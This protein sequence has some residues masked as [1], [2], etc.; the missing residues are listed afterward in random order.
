MDYQKLL[1]SVKPSGTKKWSKSIFDYMKPFLVKEI[2]RVVLSNKKGNKGPRPKIRNIDH[3]LDAIFEALDTGTKLDYLERTHNI[4]RA[5]Y[6]R[7]LK[8]IIDHRLFVKLHQK[9]LEDHSSP[10]L[11]L[12]DGSHIRSVN[13]SEG[14]NYGYKEKSKS[15]LKLTILT[16]TNKVIYLSGLHPD[17]LNDH[18]AFQDMAINHPSNQRLEVLADAGY[19]GKK[20]KKICAQN[21]YN[22]T[23]CVKYWRGKPSHILTKYQKILLKK[24]R[25]KVEH[26]FAQLKR[27]RSIQVKTTRSIKIFNGFLNLAILLVSIH[28]GIIRNGLK[29]STRVVLRKII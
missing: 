17:N 8:I 12:V 4:S 11:G 2:E 18:L 23:S 7:Y 13:G 3:A 9:L 10:S 20:F 27:F 14:V 19:N 22:I 26:V 25:S 5:T 24:N 1:S 29:R 15:A 28:N 6:Y 16:G 21:N